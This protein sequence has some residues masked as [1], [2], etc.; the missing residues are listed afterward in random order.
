MSKPDL[1]EIYK[2]YPKIIESHIKMTEAN[3]QILIYEGDFVLKHGENKFNINGSIYFNWLPNSGTYFTGSPTDQKLDAFI[4]LNRLNSFTI[5]INDLEFGTGF[6]TNTNI[7]THKGESR[8]KGVMS[9]QAVFGDKSI[10]VKT[11]VFSVPNLRQFHGHSVKK[12]DEDKISVCKGRLELENDKYL[13]LIDQSYNY[14]ELKKELEE[15]GGFILLHNG[16]ITSKKEHISFEESQE[17]FHCL[18]TFLTFLN[19]RRTSALFRNGIYGN[20]HI[21][22][23]YTNYFVDSYKPTTSWPQKNSIID[24]NKI[25]QNFSSLWSNK[26]DKD[27][28][29]SAIHWYIE[30]N[31]YS[32]FVEGSI[33]MAQTALELLY[34]W[35]II[36]NKKMITGKDSENISASN[37]IRLLLSQLN[38]NHSV[39]VGLT[40]LK[41]YVD[42]EI[43]IND[44]PEAL[45]Q[46][47]N[48]I[49]HSQ[50]EKRKK[51]SSIH[52]RAKSDALQL[53][54]WYIEMSLLGILEYNDRYYNRTSNELIMS[55]A[56]EFVPWAKNSP[57]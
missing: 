15:Y 57:T 30:S 22:C 11:I 49:V 50:V 38:I 55:K 52:Y 41:D 14:N 42:S 24:L 48:A 51:L 20:D 19:G 37:K 26:D 16:E 2:D 13:I 43:Q 33:V 23:D 36:E 5:L 47:R 44:G 31:N 35:W 6:I 53:C 32:G 8:I 3:S 17:I 29:T 45:V 56:I 21:W 10:S 1:I 54:I 25:W 27:F 9:Q 39:P 18:N 34:N 12:I 28:L 4:I 46:I 7:E 40:Y